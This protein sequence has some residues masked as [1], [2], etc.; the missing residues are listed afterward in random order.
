[1][2]DPNCSLLHRGMSGKLK[3][4]TA[5]GTC[6]ASLIFQKRSFEGAPALRR[7]SKRHGYV[8]YTL[9]TMCYGVLFMGFLNFPTFDTSKTELKKRKRC[10]LDSEKTKRSKIAT[11]LC[12]FRVGQMKRRRYYV[13]SFIGIEGIGG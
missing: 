5:E 6:G 4:E 8:W 2:K 3:H 10:L 7:V 1:M 11:Y 12:L 13:V 9:W